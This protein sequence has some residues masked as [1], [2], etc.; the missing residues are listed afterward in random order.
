MLGNRIRFQGFGRWSVY[1]D[2]APLG[3]EVEEEGQR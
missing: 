3:S 1:E 2:A